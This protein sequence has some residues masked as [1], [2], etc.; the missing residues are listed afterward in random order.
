MENDASTDRLG[1]V[2]LQEQPDKV[3]RVNL[4]S[5]CL[6]TAE[7]NCSTTKRE[8]VAVVWALFLLRPYLEGTRLT[9][10]TDDMAGC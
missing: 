8:C 9:A 7:R 6:K 5:Q 2:C 1:A 10:A 3:K 4:S